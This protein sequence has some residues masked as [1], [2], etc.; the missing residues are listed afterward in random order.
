MAVLI[1]FCTS[2]LKFREKRLA[3][4]FSMKPIK[5]FLNL[6]S[7]CKDQRN[8]FLTVV[9]SLVGFKETTA[10]GR[11]GFFETKRGMFSKKAGK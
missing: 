4:Y 2:F 10:S 8:H 9:L 11:C 6:Y 1:L 5:L 7:H 3:G